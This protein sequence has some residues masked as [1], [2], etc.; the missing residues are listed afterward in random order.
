[1]QTKTLLPSVSV[2][3]PIRNEI[4]YI[5][6][7]L[8]AIL[9]QNY[10]HNRMEVLII[11]GMSNDG[12]RDYISKILADF[13]EFPVYLIDNPARIVPAALNIG[14]DNA[15]GDIIV[16]ID[17]HCEV[18]PDFVING[19]K[20]L[21]EDKI[22]GVGGLIQTIGETE[23]SQA[24]ALAMSSPFGVGDSTFRTQK[25]VN[26]FTDSIVFPAYK[27]RTI[28]RNGYYDEEMNC[29]EDDEY[30]YRLRN[31][32][33]RLFQAGDIKSRYYCRSSFFSLLKQ[34]FRYGYWK[35][36]V[37]QK[38]PLQM[39]PRQFVPLLFVIGLIGSL[40]AA[41]FSIWGWFFFAIA[42]GSYLLANFTSSF[43][44]SARH[45]WQYLKL[46]P[47]AFFV[48]HL[49]YGLG[50]LLGLLKF[51]RKW[52]NRKEQLVLTHSE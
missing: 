37:L 18:A 27:K 35:V 44:I 9:A 30:N 36:R 12:T 19:V 51:W 8:K 39:R 47:V 48:L 33:M 10:P 26:R 23:L 28:Q 42:F 29:N 1:M 11:D 50:F 38:Y 5:E 24:I 34:Y 25:G 7:C 31:L 49:S 4:V 32:G 6:R 46:L 14:L 41:I 21:L 13:R 2:I 16:R 40:A 22:D 45:G 52:G 17:G 20:H 3:L 43:L 15:K